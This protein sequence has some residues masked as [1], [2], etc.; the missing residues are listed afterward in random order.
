MDAFKFE[1]IKLIAGSGVTG[2]GY[3]FIV[4]DVLA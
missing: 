1:D 3:V 4:H 2:G